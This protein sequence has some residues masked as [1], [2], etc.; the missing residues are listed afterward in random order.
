MSDKKFEELVIL[1][2][3]GDTYALNE[4]LKKFKPCLIKNSIINGKFDEDCFQE[5]N[6]KLINCIYKFTFNPLDVNLK[7]YL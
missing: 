3:K 2:H 7:S 4:I 6:V 1:A 5:L